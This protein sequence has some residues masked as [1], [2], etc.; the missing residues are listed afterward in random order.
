MPAQRLQ[1]PFTAVCRV[2]FIVLVWS[3]PAFPAM[4]QP[5]RALPADVRAVLERFAGTWE[6]TLTVRKP[7]AAMFSYVLRNTWVLDDHFL[8]GDTGVKPDGSHELSMFGYDPVA[9]AYPLWIFYASGLVAY[10][11]RG[12]WDEKALTMSWRSA[13]ADPIQ[14]RSRC[15]FESTRVLKCTTQVG[16]GRGGTGIEF[17]SVSQRR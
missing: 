8:H 10:L 6:V 17:E 15:R 2:V 7:R 3:M 14:Y 9:K 5:A 1:L 12:E 4:A 13:A 11:Q 16:D